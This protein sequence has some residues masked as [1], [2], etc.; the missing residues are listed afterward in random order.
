LVDFY[1]AT[2]TAGNTGDTAWANGTSLTGKTILTIDRQ[3]TVITLENRSK[4]VLS[5]QQDTSRDTY[6]FSFGA[7][8]T[9]IAFLSN[10][11]WIT[12]STAWSF[13][14]TIAGNTGKTLRT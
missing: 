1:L 14:T 4:Q 11:A 8:L 9:T 13:Q 2:V 6:S 10:K 12:R 7:V 3:C 5:E